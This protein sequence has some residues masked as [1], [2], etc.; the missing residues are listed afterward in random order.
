M[1]ITEPLPGTGY[2]KANWVDYSN[3]WREGDAEWL[4]ERTILRY[5]GVGL[6]NSDWPT[7]KF[8]QIV[9]N[10]QAISLGGGNYADRAE[11]YSKQHGKWV[12]LL[13]LDNIT[14]TK[15]DAAGVALS[16]KN[17]GGKGV[18]FTP[19]QTVM[20]N[21]I[22]V[23]GGVL[24]VDSDSVDIKVGAK[25]VKMA[26][27]SVGLIVDSPISA[28]ALSTGGTL[29]AATASISSSLT[30][31]NITMSGTLGGGGIINGNSG[32]IG[33]VNMSANNVSMS[34]GVIS[35]QGYLYGDGTSV[36]MRQRTPGSGALGGNYVQVGASTTVFGGSTGTADAY[37][38]LRIMNGKGIHWMNTGGGHQA[39]I[40]PTIYQGS[41]PGAG[42]FPDG[43]I[44][45]S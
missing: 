33:G 22:Q 11:M 31:P 6:R 25:T 19:T 42:N 24:Y 9:Y 28:T 8:G 16:H 23:M 1:T 32:T 12:P 43:T 39:W 3:Y 27:D 29:T 41:D 13:M 35:Q 5:Q 36:V 45:I 18:I 17:A 34:G 21:P 15:D 10:E 7:P 20:D 44:W 2:G 37:A 14:S 38:T 4:M 26:T 30:V 40:S